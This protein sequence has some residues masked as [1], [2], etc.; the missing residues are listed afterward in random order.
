MKVDQLW[1]T[2]IAVVEEKLSNETIF[3]LIALIREH[4]EM[5][6]KSSLDASGFKTFVDD[7]DFYNNIHYNLFDIDSNSEY[8][9]A[10]SEF[11]KYACKHIRNY[12]KEGFGATDSDT[13]E[14]SARC[15]GHS[16]EPNVKTFPHYHQA[17]D[18]VLIHYLNIGE[19]IEPLS[20]VLQDPRGAPNYPWWSKMHVINPQSG[21]TVCHP[22][23]VWHETTEW[24][25][26]NNR[27]L[28]AVN[29]KVLGHGHERQF[30]N[31]RY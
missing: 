14:L 1:A 28:I 19:S 11:E 24:K 9:K 6:K 7:G 2:P 18:V 8:S 31:T 20:L 27:D 25:G 23:F 21:T 4:N 17:S 16:I 13:V 15:F 26:D 5:K 10:V 22:S 3:D 30:R 12:L 29:F